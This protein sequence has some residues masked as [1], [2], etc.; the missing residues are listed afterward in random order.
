MWR[1]FELDKCCFMWFDGWVWNDYRALS[2]GLFDG[3]A[4]QACSFP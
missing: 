3:L 4:K 2:D 1:V